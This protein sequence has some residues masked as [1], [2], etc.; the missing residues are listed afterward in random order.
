MSA[1]WR[2][3]FILFYSILFYFFLFIYSFFLTALGRASM[4]SYVFRVCHY[5]NHVRYAG[6]LRFEMG[7]IDQQ[8]AGAQLP[9]MLPIRF[10]KW[11]GQR[12]QV[13]GRL[14]S[15]VDILR[16]EVGDMAQVP[17]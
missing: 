8:I 14:R 5:C 16:V 12:V 4:R 9:E 17:D 1:V 2:V 7:D 15:V 10:V 13:K 3:S 11:R 6:K